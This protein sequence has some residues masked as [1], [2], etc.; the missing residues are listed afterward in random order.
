MLAMMLQAADFKEMLEI[1][2]DCEL[3]VFDMNLNFYTDYELDS[4]GAVVLFVELQRRTGLEFPEE[5][6]P[7]LQSGAAVEKYV[8][9]G[10]LPEA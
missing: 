2:L 10:R 4:M 7:L 8:T 5:I 3:D 9:S 6:A 1:A